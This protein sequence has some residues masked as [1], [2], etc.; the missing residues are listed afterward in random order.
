MKRSSERFSLKIIDQTLR[1][2]FM[3]RLTKLDR[4]TSEEILMETK[5]FWDSPQD[6]YFPPETVAI[7]F[8]VSLSWL[9]LKRCDGAGIPFTKAS[10][11]R[12]RYQKQ[13]I[14]VFFDQK[15]LNN[16]SAIS[17]P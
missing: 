11:R 16:T 13:D 6:A 3:S 14:L 9:Q 5:R 2:L 10:A 15:K 17:S 8:D 4:M 7:V 1:V 12:V